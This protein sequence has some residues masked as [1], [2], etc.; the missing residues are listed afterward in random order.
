MWNFTVRGMLIPNLDGIEEFLV[1]KETVCQSQRDVTNFVYEDISLEKNKAHNEL[2]NK[3]LDCYFTNLL[4]D[5]L[6]ISTEKPLSEMSEK[7]CDRCLST[8]SY[9]ESTE[10]KVSPDYSY[11]DSSQSSRKTDT[12]ILPISLENNS[13]LTGTCAILDQFCKEFTSDHRAIRKTSI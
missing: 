2:W 10:V 3:H 4:K 11:I 12:I 9:S 5:G 6:N 13:T 7:E 1:S 8:Q